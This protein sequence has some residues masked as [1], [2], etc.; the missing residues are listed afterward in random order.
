MNPTL[1]AGFE[2]IMTHIKNQE[3][4]IK[5]LEQQNKEH[6]QKMTELYQEN[7]ELKEYQTMI[8]CVWSDLYWAN[9]AGFPDVS[10]KDLANSSDYWDNEEFV[11]KEIVEDEEDSDEEKCEECGKCLEGEDKCGEGCPAYDKGWKETHESDED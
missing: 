8:H 10:F 2:D 1:I 9:K 6:Q 5:K 7:Q 3:E 4:Q 11:K